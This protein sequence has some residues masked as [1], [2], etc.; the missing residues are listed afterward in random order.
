M[1]FQK[2]KELSGHSAG[3]YS[4]AFDGQYLYSA[5]ADNFVA[6]WNL[7]TGIQDKFAIKFE[8]P[9][10]SI[11]LLNINNFLAVGL[12]NGDLHI[13]ELAT[14]QEIKFFTQHRK[15]IFAITENKPK[16]QFYTADADG[17]ISIWSSIS[18]EL[19]LYLPLDCGKIRRINVSKEG[20]YFALA[21]Q[22]ET[23]RI[24]DTLVF[25]ETNVLSAHKNGATAVLFHPIFEDLLFSG[26]KDALLKLW[27]WKK[28]VLIEVIPAHNFV[29]YD[30]LAINKGENII[31]S[32]RDKTIKIWDT[33][34][35]SF[36]QRL[37]LKL[38][39]H[40]H[41]VNTIL[42]L[43][44]DLFCSGSDDKIIKIWNELKTN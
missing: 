16:N 4:L 5:S 15:A 26:G 24:F 33:Q 34:S 17:N 11:S 42:S 9:V 8:S 13:F 22:D 27:N 10:Y 12:A 6:R 21:C 19:M 37:D 40:K 3:I 38:G 7:E 32:S 35:L 31:T 18:L 23:I 29:I 44:E 14:R 1:I 28:N 30:I 20:S 25:N 2:L 39:G 43:S 36:L 41:S